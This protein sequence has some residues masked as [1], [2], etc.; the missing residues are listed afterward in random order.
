MPVYTNKIDVVTKITEL[1]AEGQVSKAMR[2]Q[3]LFLESIRSDKSSGR[4]TI[5]IKLDR[6][7]KKVIKSYNMPA[8]TRRST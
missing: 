2:L 7:S 6:N 4:Y 8:L 1:L 3:K 5:D